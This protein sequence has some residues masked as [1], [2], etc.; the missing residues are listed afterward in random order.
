MFPEGERGGVE[1]LQGTSKYHPNEFILAVAALVWGRPGIHASW[2]LGS[3]SGFYGVS[4]GFLPLSGDPATSGDM[5]CAFEG[6]NVTN[7][8]GLMS[9]HQ[10]FGLG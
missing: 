6:P 10:V 4:H 7:V 5:A 9:W 1:L 3:K 8:R 2:H